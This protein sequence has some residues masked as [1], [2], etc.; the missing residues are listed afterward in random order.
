[1]KW[2]NHKL[3]TGS[4]VFAF[5]GGNIPYALASMAGAIAPDLLEGMPKNEDTVE[6]ARWR[7]RHRRITHWFV[8]YA[9]LSALAFVIAAIVHSPS[10]TPGMLVGMIRGGV[11]YAPLFPVLGFVF[12]GSFFHIIEDAFCGKV[13]SFNPR[14]R[15]GIRVFRVGSAAEYIISLAILLGS[16]PGVWF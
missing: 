1:M 6:Y 7:K 3:V 8:P 4:I 16:V 9:V 10:L 15:M 12:L 5:T 13:P 2:I 14:K 11:S